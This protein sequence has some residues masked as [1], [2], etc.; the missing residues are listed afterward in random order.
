MENTVV[1]YCKRYPEKTAIQ[2]VRKLSV[3]FRKQV[4]SDYAGNISRTTTIYVMI[5]RYMHL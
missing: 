5:L 4:V 2:M 1:C 3:F